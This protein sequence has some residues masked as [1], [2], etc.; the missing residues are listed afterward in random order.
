MFLFLDRN[1]L[2]RRRGLRYREH[3]LAGAVS[4]EIELETNID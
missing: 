1:E 4:P 2:T 3:S